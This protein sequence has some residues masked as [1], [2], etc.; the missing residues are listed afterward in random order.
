MSV[1][2]ISPQQ[3]EDELV[4]VNN[5]PENGSEE[6]ISEE[7]FSKIINL[8][9][10]SIYRYKSFGQLPGDRQKDIRYL[11]NYCQEPALDFS[12]I[13]QVVL[14]DRA[15]L[16]FE[17]WPAQNKFREKIRALGY[18]LFFFDNYVEMTS[19]KPDSDISNF[20]AKLQGI[21]SPQLKKAI[22]DLQVLTNYLNKE[23]D[24][25]QQQKK[26]FITLKSLG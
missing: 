1:E 3:K 8:I 11:T 13:L 12:K 19:S 16:I 2:K 21:R 9:V 18:D 10:A 6:Y 4:E 22:I 17:D 26:A 20:F 14:G 24:I 15:E 25:P 7:E 5:T 23:L